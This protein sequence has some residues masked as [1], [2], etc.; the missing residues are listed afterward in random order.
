MYSIFD[1]A[2]LYIGYVQY[3]RRGNSV[4]RLRTVFFSWCCNAVLPC[5]CRVGITHP[6][7]RT[8]Q[9]SSNLLDGLFSVEVIDYGIFSVEVIEDGIF[10]VKV[11]DDGLFYVEVIDFHTC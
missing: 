11:I 9:V 2:T 7:C 4:H 8:S 6:F 10:Y 1:A 5:R 3:S